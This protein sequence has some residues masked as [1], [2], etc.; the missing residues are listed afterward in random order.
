MTAATLAALLILSI[1]LAAVAP[2]R[3]ATTSVENEVIVA[4]GNIADYIWSSDGSKIAYVKC[5]EGQPWGE[6][7]IGDWDGYGVTNLQLLH[8]EIEAGGLEDWQGDWILFRIRNQTE[9]PDEYYGRGELWKMRDDGTDLTQITFTYLNGIRT[10]WS[11]PYYENIGTAQWGR[12]IP[13]TDL[14][15]FTAHDGNGWWKAYTCHANG[16]D[17]WKMIS[18]STYSFTIGMSPTGNKLLWGTAVYYDQPTTLMASNVNGSDVVTVKT[19]TAVT[20]PLMLVDGETIVYG[21]P[22]GSILAIQVNGTDDRVILD[23]EYANYWVNYHPIDGQSFLMRSDRGSDGHYHIFSINVDGTIL[24][25]LTEGSH[26]DDSAIYSPDGTD[27]LYRRVPLYLG[28]PS[29]ELVIAGAALPVLDLRL[30]MV[31]IITMAAATVGILY[32]RHRS[33]RQVLEQETVDYGLEEESRRD[34]WDT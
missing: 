7:W 19:F 30:P 24:G 6:L 23:D 11:N 18:L 32:L 13:G 17:G 10:E 34:E 3:A 2:A 4:S 33:A 21:H 14:V 31:I 8:S 25:Q 16:T 27:L 12:F 28:A 20:T 29:H 22:N 5:P 26:D 15:Y 1:V 9:L